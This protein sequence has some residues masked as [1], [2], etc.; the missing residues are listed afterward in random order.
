MSNHNT[1][2][3]KPENG[4][5]SREMTE[6]KNQELDRKIKL[7]NREKN[8]SKKYGQGPAPWLSG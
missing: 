7:N 5:Y 4:L 2:E 3:T 8:I 1:L 6:E